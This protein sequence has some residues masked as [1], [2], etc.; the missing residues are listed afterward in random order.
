MVF[1]AIIIARIFVQV[2][3]IPYSVL[4][5]TIIMMATIGAFA[6]KN[7]AV[8]VKLMA[9]SGLI[10]F[11]V[12]TCRFNSSALILGLVLGVICESNLRRAYTIA[13]GDN[14]LQVTLNVFSRPVTAVAI[15][16]SVLVLLNPVLKPHLAKLKKP[17]ATV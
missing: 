13:N 2:L 9:I 6:T 10:G 14:L 16:I 4:A 8:D 7:T 1:A 5:P 15:L 3:K 11:V 17:K 12:V